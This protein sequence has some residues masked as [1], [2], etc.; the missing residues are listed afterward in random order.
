MYSLEVRGA[1]LEVHFVAGS[2]PEIVSVLADSLECTSLE[3]EFCLRIAK[4]RPSG[5]IIRAST[6]GQFNAICLIPLDPSGSN[7]PTRVLGQNIAI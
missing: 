7:V 2:G 1:P 6:I 5:L 3:M 4:Q